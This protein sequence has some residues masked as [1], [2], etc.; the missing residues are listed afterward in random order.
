M[1]YIV[2]EYSVLDNDEISNSAKLLYGYI[3]G[4]SQNDKG[5]C[6]ATTKALCDLMNMKKRN[7]LYCLNELKKFN[8]ISSTVIKNKRYIT[9]TINKFMEI[10]DKA[11][12]N[13]IDLFDYDWLSDSE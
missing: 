4:L 6:F 5:C 7:L 13:G 1:K 3:V 9:P 10:R 11:V 8:Y 2:L 12:K